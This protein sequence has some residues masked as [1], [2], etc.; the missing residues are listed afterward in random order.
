MAYE[1]TIIAKKEFKAELVREYS[2]SPIP[3]RL[4][5]A[6]NVMELHCDEDNDMWIVWNYEFEDGTEGDEV[7]IGL[8]RTDEGDCKMITGYDGVFELPKEAIE[9]LKE[10]GFNTEEVEI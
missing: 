9:L 2:C 5:S 10:A 3:E 1:D 8:E 6:D 7:V 4:G